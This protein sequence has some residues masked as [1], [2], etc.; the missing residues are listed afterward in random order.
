[1]LSPH[2]FIRPVIPVLR[3][4]GPILHH[5]HH[6][7]QL[8]LKSTPFPSLHF[9]ALPVFLLQEESSAVYS[10][11]MDILQKMLLK[12]RRDLQVS[13]IGVWLWLYQRAS[14]LC[15]SFEM[16]F[17]VPTAGLGFEMSRSLPADEGGVQQEPQS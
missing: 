11:K 9:L 7:L 1:M 17:P 13:I 3:L 15:G 16:L 12:E 8:S 5:S 4:S 6:E 14:S 10:Q 2:S